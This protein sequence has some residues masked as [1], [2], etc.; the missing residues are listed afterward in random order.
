MFSTAFANQNFELSMHVP[1]MALFHGRSSG[2]HWKMVANIV[3]IPEPMTIAIC[4]M[5]IAPT[6]RKGKEEAFRRLYYEIWKLNNYLHDLR[7]SDAKN[8]AIATPKGYSLT[9]SSFKPKCKTARSNKQTLQLNT[10]EHKRLPVKFETRIKWIEHYQRIFVAQSDLL[11]FFLAKLMLDI[12]NPIADSDDPYR[13]VKSMLVLFGRTKVA[14][15]KTGGFQAERLVKE[16][17]ELGGPTEGMREALGWVRDIFLGM[18]GK[19]KR[20]KSKGPVEVIDLE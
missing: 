2:T 5:G 3:A 1:L 18:G 14:I 8:E 4:N 7:S 17:G 19:S 16:I 11:T 10:N 12:E 13:N 20:G 15:R 9:F 6:Y